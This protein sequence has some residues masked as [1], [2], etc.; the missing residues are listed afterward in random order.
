MN[1]AIFLDRDGT[2]IR[3]RGAVRSRSQVRFYRGFLSTLRRL[4]REYLLFVITNQ[5]FVAKGLITKSEVMK[6]HS[7]LVGSLRRKGIEIKK[8]YCCTHRKEDG[9][10]CRK[11][12]TYFVK[13][14]KKRFNLDLK[15]SFV[16]GDH[17]TDV[18]LA[19]NAGMRGIFL[20]TGHGREHERE[21]RKIKGDVGIF[22]NLKAAL[23]GILRREKI[24]KE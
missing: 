5:P 14:A 24:K 2:L 8:V 7:F 10:A 3:D 6:V 18:Q 21:M 9:C 15:N 13:K 19:L 12:K 1:K 20:L 22:R 4:N 16:I 23:D 17:D 11:P